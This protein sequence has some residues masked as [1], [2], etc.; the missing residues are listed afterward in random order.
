MSPGVTYSPDTSIVFAALDAAMFVPT[1]AIL[2]S[3]TATSRRPLILFLGS[4]TWPPFRTKSYSC[5]QTKPT[6][7]S[8]NVIRIDRYY[9]NRELIV[10]ELATHAQTGR[11]F[12]GSN[13]LV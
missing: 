12:T 7:R 5:A 4:I 3:L 6:L 1:S 8:R 2:P 11:G 9:F 13:A 10:V